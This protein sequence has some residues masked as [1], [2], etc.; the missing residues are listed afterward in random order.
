MGGDASALR[1]PVEPGPADGPDHIDHDRGRGGGGGLRRRGDRWR[2]S[3][4][5]LRPGEQLAADE[6]QQ[7]KATGRDQDAPARELERQLGHVAERALETVT[8]G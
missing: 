3:R 1:E 5:R 2:Q 4:A 6:Q 8:S 7:G